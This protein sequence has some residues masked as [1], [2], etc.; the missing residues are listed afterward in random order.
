M[1]TFSLLVLSMLLLTNWVQGS[2]AVEDG[3]IE[4]QVEPMEAK[5]EFVGG[6]E[7]EEG[8]DGETGDEEGLEWD[9]DEE[10][11]EEESE[12]KD[13]EDEEGKCSVGVTEDILLVTCDLTRSLISHRLIKPFISFFRRGL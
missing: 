4:A 3:N 11:E 5:E 12:D 9:E 10:E 13:E 6:S 2:I 8:F 1:K 7:V